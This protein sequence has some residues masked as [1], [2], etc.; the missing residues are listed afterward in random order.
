MKA[1]VGWLLL[2]TL[3]LLTAVVYGG[4]AQPQS[5][6]Q[7]TAAPN[8][9]A[10]PEPALGLEPKAIE[11]LKAACSRLAAASTMS[12]TTVVSY[13]SPS[14]LAALPLVYTTKSDV[15][16]QKPN[17]LRVITAGDGPATEFYY[18]GKTMMAF[19][20][21][22]N[23]VAI[24]DAP[25]TIDATLEAAYNTAAIYFPFTDVVVADPYKDL[26]EGLIVAFYIGQ[27]KVVG[28][29]TTDMVAYGN[30]KVFVQAWIGTEDKLPRMLRAVYRDDPE[31]LRNQLEFSNWKLGVAVTTDTFK[32]AKA[33][34]AKRINF[35]PPNPPADASQKNQQ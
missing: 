29:V 12:F 28:G 25:A 27:S 1:I 13:E 4:D 5:Q 23:L 14:L 24:A 18:D 20:P 34:G 26:S 30:D 11:L 33:A 21:A 10:L 17:K 9:P 32:S 6:T 31:R 8:A 19:A 35:A 7:A 22:E 2:L 3:T 15:T 16:V